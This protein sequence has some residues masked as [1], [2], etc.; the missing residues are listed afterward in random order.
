MTGPRLEI[1]CSGC[2]EVTLVRTEAVYEGFTRIGEAYICTSCGK[3][4]ASAEET[5]FAA[6]DKKPQVFTEADR[7]VALT[8]FDADE[9]QHCCGWCK[10]MV[11]NPFGQR[12]GVSN[13]FTEA[14][15]ICEHFE[16]QGSST[17]N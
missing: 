4:Y 14:T 11:L 3:R 15:D 10:H 1:R 2:G 13:R 9:R 17:S 6:A 7:E 5:P 16:K 8:V 12:C